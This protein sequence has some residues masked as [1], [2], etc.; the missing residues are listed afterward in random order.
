MD[1]HSTVYL[2]AL[3]ADG[4]ATRS[5]ALHAERERE[6]AGRLDGDGKTLVFNDDRSGHDGIYKQSLDGQTPEPL[7][8]GTDGRR[9]LMR[10][11]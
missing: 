7:V 6:R 10:E 1:G 8:V 2:A 3:E 5:E 4:E 11:P 9:R